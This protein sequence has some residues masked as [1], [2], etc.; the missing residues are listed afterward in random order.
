MKKIIKQ[1]MSVFFL[2]VVFIVFV[3]NFDK[4]KPALYD[5]FGMSM[6]M[7]TRHS[8]PKLTWEHLQVVFYSSFFSVIIGILLGIYSTT[9]AGKELRGIF[10]KV[11]YLGQM[12][13]T[14]AI[15]TFMVSFTGFGAKPAIV[16]L[17]IFG[18]LPIYV[19]TVSGIE[20][21]PG[22]IIEV[23]EG[24]GMN[25]YQKFKNVILPMA[26]PVIISGLRTAL[27]I[28]I[29]AATL[30]YTVGGGGLG[31]LLFSSLKSR[32]NV[33]ILEGTVTICL[34]AVIVD[35]VLKNIEEALSVYGTLQTKENRYG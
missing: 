25:T 15:L 1:W 17:I 30:S 34:L 14:I 23:A 24:I 21:I 11:T 10:E 16:A 19:S 26:L 27:I 7:D 18:I 20:T 13:P 12:I 22:D 4:M 28:N 31:V 33:F 2:I 32:N 35:R 8:L 3:L 9:E 6:S 29:S 5:F